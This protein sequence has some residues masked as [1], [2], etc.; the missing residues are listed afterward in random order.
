MAILLVLA[1]MV[2]LAG[3]TKTAVQT[4][5]VPRAYQAYTN[6]AFLLDVRTQEEWNK[7]H[8]PNATLI[9]LDEL[10]SRLQEIPHDKQIIVVCHSGNRSKLGANILREAGFTRVSSMAGGMNAWEQAGYPTTGK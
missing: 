9:P 10:P 4:V 2:Y 7:I 1:G 6:G 3:G 8:I 5:D